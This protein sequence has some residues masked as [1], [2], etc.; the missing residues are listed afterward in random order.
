[1][2]CHRVQFSHRTDGET[3]AM[4]EDGVGQGSP[5]T[6]IPNLGLDSTPDPVDFWVLS[7]RQGPTGSA[8][9]GPPMAGA[10][11]CGQR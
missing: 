3:E 9:Q 7:A 6:C 2:G 8:R 4:R 10:S 5:S 11:A 1:M